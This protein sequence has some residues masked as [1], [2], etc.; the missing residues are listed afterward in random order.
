MTTTVTSTMWRHMLVQGGRWTA[1][2]LAPFTGC[3]R[4][5]TDKLLKSMAR[6]GLVATYRSGQR[7]NGRAYGV[8]LDCKIPQ[9]ITLE[10][11]IAA[12]GG[13]PKRLERPD[14]ELDPPIRLKAIPR[15]ELGIGRVSS[16]FALG[17]G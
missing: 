14:D 17:A 15:G 12:C 9:G 4:D 6:G 5:K 2:E 13:E 16:V 3:D 7:K 11:L 8:H 1:A 10:E